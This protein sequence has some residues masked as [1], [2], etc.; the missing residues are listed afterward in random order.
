GKGRAGNNAAGGIEHCRR[1]LQRAVFETGKTV[2]ALVTNA[3]PTQGRHKSMILAYSRV[4]A[5]AQYFRFER[6]FITSLR[7]SLRRAAPA[8]AQEL[9][10]CCCCCSCCSSSCVATGA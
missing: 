7:T 8:A 10:S 6:D 9:H 2:Q 4:T 5:K 3:I 1:I